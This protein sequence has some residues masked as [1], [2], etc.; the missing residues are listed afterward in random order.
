MMLLLR[1]IPI[2]AGLAGGG[3]FFAQVRSASTYPWMLA[4]VALIYIGSVISIYWHRWRGVEQIRSLIPSVIALIALASG[5]LLTEGWIANYL[6]PIFAG[7]ILYAVM[8]LRFLHTFVPAGYPV[9]GISH[10]NLFLVPFVFWIAGYTSV[11]L[12]IFLLANKWI[13]VAVMGFLGLALFYSTSHAEATL[14][15]RWRWT[16]IGLWI[17]IQIGL[18]EMFLPLNLFIHAA[19]AAL[20][21]GYAL[22][23]RRYGIQPPIPERMIVMECVGAI[24]LLIAL[25][26]TAR[27]L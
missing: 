20:C 24:S 12:V 15:Q 4:P 25:I 19:I 27:W 11:G 1:L 16:W 23:A 22:R 13:P 8:E 3:L 26:A 9:N 5:L 18:L 7:V 21:A 17:G 6:I 10:I 2:V 14:A